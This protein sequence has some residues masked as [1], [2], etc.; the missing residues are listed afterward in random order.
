MKK[1]GLV[2][3]SLFM[4][5]CYCVSSTNNT[6]D[7]IIVQ[8]Q[9][10]DNTDTSSVILYT[11]TDSVLYIDEIGNEGFGY[12]YKIV[13]DSLYIYDVIGDC[14]ECG[15]ITKLSNDSDTIRIKFSQEEIILK[16]NENIISI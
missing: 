9:V 3:I 2:L 6:N 1:I 13:G 15:I 8:Y 4:C 10:V 14:W 7:S 16:N 12:P 11:F 5:V